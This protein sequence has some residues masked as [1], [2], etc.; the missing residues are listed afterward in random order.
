MSITEIFVKLRTILWLMD[1]MYK[2]KNIKNDMNILKKFL[3]K[4]CGKNRITSL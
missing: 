4:E 1:E 3:S 2:Y